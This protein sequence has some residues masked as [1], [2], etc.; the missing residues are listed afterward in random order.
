MDINRP[1]DLPPG[2]Q[3]IPERRDNS[4]GPGEY[5]PGVTDRYT[6][7][8]QIHGATI[9]V[10]KSA[11]S[12]LDLAGLVALRNVKGQIPLGRPSDRCGSRAR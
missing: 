4:N 10:P 7:N 9:D 3:Q 2:R 8:I 1:R 11:L 6:V 5:G 12:G